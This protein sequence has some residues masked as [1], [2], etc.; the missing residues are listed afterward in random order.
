VA[1]HTAFGT[2]A[3]TLREREVIAQGLCPQNEVKWER[4]EV[5]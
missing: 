1:L 5:D 4:H 3:P 2:F